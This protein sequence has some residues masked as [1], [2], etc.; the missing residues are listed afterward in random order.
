MTTCKKTSKGLGFCNSIKCTGQTR[1][2]EEGFCNSIKCTGQTRTIEEQGT[3]RGV[4]IMKK[5]RSGIFYVGLCS[6]EG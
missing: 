4:R 5:P 1:T 6:R 2:I 3:P